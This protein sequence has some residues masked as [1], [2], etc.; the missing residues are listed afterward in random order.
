MKKLIPLLLFAWLLTGCQQEKPLINDPA[1]LSDIERMLKIQKELTANSKIPIWTVLDKTKPGE[2]EQ[3]L[4]FMYAYMPLSDLADYPMDFIRANVRKSLMAR[5]ETTWGKQIPEEV[6]LHFV[7]PLRVNNENLDSFRLVYYDELKT[8]IKG[9]SMKDAA[10]EINHWCHEKVNYRGTDSRTSAPMSTISK[11]FGRCGEESTFT[12]S[13][14]RAAGI[15]S[16]QV[17]TPRW[18]HT[19]DNHAWVE[20]WIDGTWHY[21]G[22]C[23][24]DT[25]LDRG[26]FSEPSQR[27]MLVHTKTYG[28]YFGT[29]EILDASDRFSELNLTPGYAKTKKITVMVTDSSGNPAAGAKVEFK[30][31]NYAEFYPIATVLSDKEG[32]AKFTTGMGDLLVWASGNGRFAFDQLHVPAID[33]LRLVLNRSVMENE[34]FN[35]DLVPPKVAKPLS[36][37]S[38]KEKKNNE[39]RLAFEDSI[40]NRTM[41]LFKDSAWIISYAKTNRM[42]EDTL[43]RTL[44]L[45]YGNWKEMLNYI[46]SNK[47]KAR[48]LMFPLT[49]GISEKDLSDTKA[50]VLT[51]HLAQTMETC[52]NLNIPSGYF[53]KYVLAPRIGMEILSPWRSFLWGKMGPEMAAA[54]RKDMNTLI[55]WIKDNISVDPVANRHSRAPLTPVGVFNLRVA[56]P[57]SRNIFY[58]ATCRTFGVPARLNPETLIP[59]YFQNGT[60][61]RANLEIPKA[62]PE[63]GKLSLKDLNNTMS[64]QYS[65]H[66]TIARIENGA[67]QTLEFE[68]GRKLAEFPD[69]VMLE[70]GQY[71]LVTGKRLSDASV[72]SS[73]TFFKVS[74][75]KPATVEVELRK[76][77]SALKS[78][79][80]LETGMVILKNLAGNREV[81]LSELMK[82]QNAI[83]VLLDP[84]SEPSKHILNDLSPYKEQFDKWKGQFIFVIVPGKEM[85][86]ATFNNYKLPAQKSFASDSGG[87]LGQMLSSITGKISENSLP[88]VF[89][90]QPSGDV[91]MTSAGY[92]IG[93]GE[94]L[95]QLIKRLEGEKLQKPVPSCTTL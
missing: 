17:Y 42:A 91:I 51:D 59:E 63:M 67:C 40:R 88:V 95:L 12:V 11:T 73:I 35:Y 49:Y 89:F 13:A 41:S 44:R 50:S 9:L 21:M 68:E 6:F 82:N 52:G 31:Y 7:L 94:Q 19:D 24:P 78:L 46:E 54:T 80:R 85:K 16:R 84:E 66:F 81:R 28:H 1:R 3:A 39:R 62:Q 71:M 77:G 32:A 58:V 4:R 8:R 90:C 45:S 75:D 26:W 74:K 76:E 64:P 56:D 53:E 69:P 72:L 60:W 87:G 34:K 18:A 37:A 30:L 14:M 22:A 61:L 20:V 25:D 29:E 23:E 15:P 65:L 47:G 5:N 2:E 86:S 83:V 57:V 70:T 36:P 48:K 43:I 79:G 38:E 92:K 10:L 27:T 55:S 33:T 93:I